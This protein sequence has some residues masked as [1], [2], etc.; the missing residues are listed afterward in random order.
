MIQFFKQ[1]PGA[2]IDPGWYWVRMR[3]N[4]ANGS[5]PPV[6]YGPCIGP[7]KTKREAQHDALEHAKAFGPF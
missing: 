1:R 4:M 6:P 2:D 7:F 5:L 3:E